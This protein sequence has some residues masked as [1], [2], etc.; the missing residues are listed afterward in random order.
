MIM[1]GFSHNVSSLQDLYSAVINKTDYA[2][3]APEYYGFTHENKDFV[4]K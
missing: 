4:Y 2:V 1:H 3:L